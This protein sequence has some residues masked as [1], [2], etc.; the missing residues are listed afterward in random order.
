MPLGVEAD[1]LDCDIVVSEFKLQSCKYFYFRKRM[2][3]HL[4]IP[5]S[6]NNFT[7]FTRMTLALNN[8]RSLPCH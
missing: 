7:I 8:P 1:V 6:L 2:N 5:S 3:T 4:F